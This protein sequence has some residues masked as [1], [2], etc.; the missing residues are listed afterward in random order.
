M[1]LWGV[2]DSDESKPKYLNTADAKNCIAKQKD[3]F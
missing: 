2:S 3:G 1:A